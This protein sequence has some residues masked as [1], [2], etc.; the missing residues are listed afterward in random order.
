M[1][2]DHQRQVRQERTG[3]RDLG[4]SQRHRRWGWDCPAVDLDFLF[5]EY[6]RGKASAL[7]E[8]KHENA[9]PQYASHPTYQAMIDL[10]TRAGIPVFACRYTGDYSTYKVVPLNSFAKAILSEPRTMTEREY[11]GFLYEIRGYSAPRDLLDGLD[12]AI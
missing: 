11:V 10:G 4:L 2:T 5:L 9:A 7:I 8:Y 1:L 12:I 6:D 3:W